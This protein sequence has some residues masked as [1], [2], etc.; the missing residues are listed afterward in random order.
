MEEQKVNADGT[1]HTNNIP[2]KVQV[3]RSWLVEAD[4]AAEPASDWDPC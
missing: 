3:T 4:E 1:D 2:S